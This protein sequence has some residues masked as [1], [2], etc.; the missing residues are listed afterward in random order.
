MYFCNYW[1]TENIR[2]RGKKISVG[3]LLLTDLNST[4]TNT[5]DDVNYEMTVFRHWTTCLIPKRRKI[6]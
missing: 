3:L 5:K 6:D 4:L 2:V 1:Y